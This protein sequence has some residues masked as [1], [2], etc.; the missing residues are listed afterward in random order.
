MDFFIFNGIMMDREA[1]NG[2]IN[3]YILKQGCKTIL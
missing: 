3:V 1:G 2:K